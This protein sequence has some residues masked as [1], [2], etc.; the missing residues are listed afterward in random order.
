MQLRTKFRHEVRK[1]V[2]YRQ[3]KAAL[4]RR[5]AAAPLSVVPRGQ[6]N[7][8]NIDAKEEQLVAD[9]AERRQPTT[10]VITKAQRRHVGRS[11]AAFAFN[12]IRWPGDCQRN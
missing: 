4:A 10:V 9:Q 8:E 2:R 6:R 3:A 5:N 12:E 7:I 1:Q 11:P